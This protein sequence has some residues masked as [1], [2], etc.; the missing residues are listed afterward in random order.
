MSTGAAAAPAGRFTAAGPAAERRAALQRVF[1][2]ARIVRSEHHFVS[3][4]RQAV[5]QETLT[6]LESEGTR[7]WGAN[8]L[9]SRR[10]T[11]IDACQRA[12]PADMP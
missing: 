7:F 2:I 10:R 9:Y 5:L 11:V 3:T 4:T 1:A 12:W 8:Q 6:R